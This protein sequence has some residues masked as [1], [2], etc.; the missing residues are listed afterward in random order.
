MT[1]TYEYL[2]DRGYRYAGLNADGRHTYRRRLFD[3]T[4]VVLTI[5]PGDTLQFE[6]TISDE[7]SHVATGTPE[8]AL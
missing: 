3:G 1:I 5:G 4:D 8:T 7:A 2:A 6:D